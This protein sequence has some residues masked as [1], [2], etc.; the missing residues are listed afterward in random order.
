MLQVTAG[1]TCEISIGDGGGI[2]GAGTD[3]TVDCGEEHSILCT[4]GAGGAGDGSNG[5]DGR[6]TSTGAT[7]LSQFKASNSAPGGGGLGS[8]EG[9]ARTGQPGSVTIRY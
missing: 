6:C 9:E 8:Q 7:A 4:A 1:V 2:G 3:T 5:L